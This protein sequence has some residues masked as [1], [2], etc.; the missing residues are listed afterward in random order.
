MMIVPRD[1]KRNSNHDGKESKHEQYG[2]RWRSKWWH[3]V[4]LE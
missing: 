2:H 4:L 3:Y 1:E